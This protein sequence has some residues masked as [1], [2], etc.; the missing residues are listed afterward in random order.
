MKVA[1]VSVHNSFTATGC[2]S[3][4]VHDFVRTFEAA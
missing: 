2:F 1:P 4:N 3:L